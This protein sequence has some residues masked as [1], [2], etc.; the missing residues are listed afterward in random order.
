MELSYGSPHMGHDLSTGDESAASV[1][2]PVGENRQSGWG[3]KHAKGVCGRGQK[4][5]CPE[6]Q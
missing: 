4:R 1:Y 5:G 6:Q 3:M 2:D